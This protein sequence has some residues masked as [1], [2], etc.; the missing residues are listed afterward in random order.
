MGVDLT[1]HMANCLYT[2]LSTDTGCFKFSSTTART[3]IIAAKLMEAGARV[4][5]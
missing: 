3:H 1:A 4:K 5:S 2:G